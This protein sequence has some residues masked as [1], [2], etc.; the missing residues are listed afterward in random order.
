MRRRGSKQWN[1][2]MHREAGRYHIRRWYLIGGF[3]SPRVAVRLFAQLGLRKSHIGSRGR[4]FGVLVATTG[5]AD[6][7]RREEA[8]GPSMRRIPGGHRNSRNDLRVRVGCA[9]MPS[10]G[11]LGSAGNA[12]AR[13]PA[14]PYE[15][16]RAR[17]TR[18]LFACFRA[19]CLPER[20]LAMGAPGSTN[21]SGSGRC[22]CARSGTW[23]WWYAVPVW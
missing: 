12:A 5:S 16:L 23:G 15:F 9:Q 17:P 4:I 10:P 1:H 14:C 22:S 19:P 3:D 13:S 18:R 11:H 7:A 2:R 8:C 6:L 20:A 21:G